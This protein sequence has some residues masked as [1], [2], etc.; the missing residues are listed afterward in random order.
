ML[1]QDVDAA[2]ARTQ[3]VDGIVQKQVAAFAPAQLMRMPGA[4]DLL[5]CMAGQCET[6]PMSGLI[7]QCAQAQPNLLGVIDDLQPAQLWPV[8]GLLWPGIADTQLIDI[9]T[10]STDPG[11]SP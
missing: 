1:R 5:G 9:R 11:G 4:L 2:R 8:A 10:K 3:A 7:R 6:G